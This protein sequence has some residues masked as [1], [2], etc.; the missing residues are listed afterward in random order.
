[1]ARTR[2]ATPDDAPFLAWVL[3]EAARSHLARGVW[4]LAMPGDEDVRLANLAACIGTDPV[5]FGHWSRFL[6]AEVD[7]EPAAALAGYENRAHGESHMGRALA[8]GLTGR[9]W[10]GQQLLEMRDRIAVFETPDYPTPDGVWIVEW[11]AT[12]PEQRGQGLVREL[13]EAI[14]EAGR[15]AGFDRA[16]IGILIGNEAARHAYERA[17]FVQIEEHRHPEFERALGSPGLAR[18]QRDL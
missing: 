17:G 12:R 18:F 4:D 10:T 11:V 13:L 1:M 8:R 16:Q 6:V 5:H 7:G 15:A 9:G 14:L 3:Q 2:P